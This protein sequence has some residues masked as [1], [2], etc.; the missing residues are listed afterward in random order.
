MTRAESKR[1]MSPRTRFIKIADTISGF[2][3][4]SMGDERESLVITKAYTFALVVG[5]CLL[6]VIGMILA[7]FGYWGFALGAVAF[8]GV[9]S[10]LAIG[11]AA[12]QGVS[13]FGLNDKTSTKRKRWSVFTTILLLCVML[14]ARVF[15]LVQGHPVFGTHGLTT[16]VSLSSTASEASGMVVGVIVGLLAVGLAG[17]LLKRREAASAQQDDE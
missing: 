5:V 13:V 7:L 1:T 17:R 14:G 6:L 9:Q 11:Y 8:G 3:E 10:Y 12:A 15:H 4:G 16:P 2:N